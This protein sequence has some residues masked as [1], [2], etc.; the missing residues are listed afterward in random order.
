LCCRPR[1]VRQFHAQD[2]IL[3]LYRSEVGLEEVLRE[4]AHLGFGLAAEQPPGGRHVGGVKGV[5]RRLTMTAHLRIVD[6][7]RHSAKN[8]NH[9]NRQQHGKV[10]TRVV[11][12]LP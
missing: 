12:K 5:E 11:D 2:H 1:L 9:G 7:Q 8:R 4:T 6:R 3:R 10:A